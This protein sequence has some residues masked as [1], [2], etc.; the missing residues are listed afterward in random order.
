MTDAKDLSE[1]FLC[2]E[3]THSLVETPEEE[4][5][6]IVCPQIVLVT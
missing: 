2:A 1:L 4:A 5:K 3:E 6:F